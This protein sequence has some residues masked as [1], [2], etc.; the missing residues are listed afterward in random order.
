M[1]NADMDMAFDVVGTNEANGTRCGPMHPTKRCPQ[2]HSSKGIT[3]EYTNN[4]ILWLSDFS[5]AFQKMSEVGHPNASLACVG[6]S[7]D[8]SIF[9][10]PDSEHDTDDT[11][12][13]V[14]IVFAALV[15]LGVAGFAYIKRDA[16]SDTLRIRSAPP[17]TT[18]RQSK[19]AA[20]FAGKEATVTQRSFLSALAGLR[21][22]DEVGARSNS[23]HVAQGPNPRHVDVTR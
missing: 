8:E 19:V 6:S 9:S 5:V 13:A 12:L 23:Y 10:T 18:E 1:L 4:N 21:D 3:V 7:C 17:P 22:D 11:G 15:C 2:P 16:I 14:G 20:D